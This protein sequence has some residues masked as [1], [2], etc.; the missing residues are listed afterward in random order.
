MRNK[1]KLLAGAV[2]LAN[3]STINAV[4]MTDTILVSAKAPIV[5]EEFSGSVSV[6]SAEEI[7][8]SGA[9]SVAEALNGLPGVM[10]GAGSGNAK[11]EIRIRG[12]AGEYGL[13]LIDGKRVP[14]A[15]RNISSSPANRSNWV[16]VENIER[17]EVIRGAA[18]SLYGADALSGVINIITKKAGDKWRSSVTLSG[19]EFQGESAN[20]Q[21][22][23]LATSG[24]INDTFDISLSH[25]KQEED[26]IFHDGNSIQ[27]EREL[28]NSQAKLG[29][30]FSE[31][32]RLEVGLLY[33]E[34]SAESDSDILDQEKTLVSLDYS[35]KLDDFNLGASLSGARDNVD[36]DGTQWVIEDKNLGFDIDGEIA[37]DHYLSGGIS[38]REESVE[39]ESLDFSDTF[40]SSNLYGQDVI[41][42]NDNNS[43]TL[44]FSFEDHNKYGAAFSPKLYWANTLND[45]WGLKL[46]YSEGRIAPAVRE[47]SSDY[48]VSAGPTRTYRGNDDLKPEESKTTEFSMSYGG[49]ELFASF[50]LFNSDVDNLI[51]TVDVDDSASVFDNL[52]SNVEEA[53]IRGLETELTWDLASD[54]QV[55]FNYTYTDAINKDGSDNDGNQIAKRPQH[56]ANIKYTQLVN[57]IDANVSVSL[58]GVSSQYTDDE[59]SEEIAGYSTLDLGLVKSINDHL[60]VRANIINLNDRMVLDD[61]NQAIHV[62]RELRLALSGSF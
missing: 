20:A 35:G 2:V 31:E 33:G 26:E 11:D 15:E 30:N 6:I 4:E 42:L 59:N 8:L 56:V 51:T 10:V 45:E 57:L 50:T 24:K 3:T 25:D 41:D 62:G 60:E 17:I 18:S 43:I 7:K 13:I 1:A 14:N 54:S 52:Y 47:G 40:K 12:M 16:S 58:Q 46:G 48:V 55:S 44:G 36:D 37:K 39:R 29:I 32:E 34:E 22:I 21:G 19:A 53:Q 27:A 28:V 38:Y 9:T 23:N 5:A 61:S 49:D